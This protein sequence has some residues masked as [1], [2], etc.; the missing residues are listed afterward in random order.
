[1]NDFST[2]LMTEGDYRKKIIF[3]AIPVFIGNLFQQLYNTADS[4]IVGNLVG[5]S[6]LAA[7]SSTG[8]IIFLVIGFFMGFSM[9]AGVI[10]ARNIGAND[11]ANISKA[12]HT[13]VAMG[14]FFSV[15][16][17][18]LGVSLSSTL[19]RWM[20]TPQEVF[21]PASL[22]LKIYFGGATGLIMYNTFVGI[23]QAS[24]DS[25]H[26]LY[27][28][29]FSS[30]INIV[31]DVFF[32]IVFHMGVDGAALATIISQFLSMLL[33][34]HRL[35]HIGEDIRIDIHKIAIDKANMKEIITFGLPTALQAC[36][37][38]LSNLLI[39]S[40]I[41]SFGS[42]AMA[43]IG[44]YS[45]LEGFSFLPVTSFSMAMSTFVS[46]NF[47]AK[48]KERMHQGIRFGLIGSVIS[49][50]CIGIL[51]YLFAP[52][53]MKG[54]SQ[55]PDVIYYGTERARVCSLFYCLLGFSH[56]TSA[57]MRGV[58]KPMT[59]MVVMLICWCAIRVLVLFTVGMVYHNIYLTFW[60]YPIT[61]GLSSV[62][63][64]WYMGRLK[65][66]GVL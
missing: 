39:Q 35:L 30:L 51:F 36:V 7:V 38:D 10:I 24:G 45:K 31:L 20:Q 52:V 58:G 16:I 14:L 9:G 18:I 44:A 55:N 57:V 53:L 37:I 5:S 42:L 40:Y 64:L 54:F 49:I 4:L 33:A 61:W 27:Y 2:N 41:N 60:I 25:K 62:A 13:T 19:L 1:M 17:S 46:Q 56:V 48:K 65:K 12:V 59:P 8:S 26:P 6:A 66:S 11:K 43:G 32:I 29:I 15:F 23:L 50:E 22:Y 34:L 21:E 63:Y 28:L 47:G 3:F